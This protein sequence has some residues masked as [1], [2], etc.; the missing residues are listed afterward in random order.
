[1]KTATGTHSGTK[2]PSRRHVLTEEDRARSGTPEARERARETSVFRVSSLAEWGHA[3]LC[4][5]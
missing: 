4:G 5:Q 1:M 2:T 3:S